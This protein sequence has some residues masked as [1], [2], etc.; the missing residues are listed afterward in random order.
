MA[1]KKRK[2]GRKKFKKVSFKVSSREQSL[3]EQC[4]QLEETTLNKFIKKAIREKVALYE[5]QLK[6]QNKSHVSENQLTLFSE[7]KAGDQISIFDKDLF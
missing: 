7:K 3:I 1:P 6:G 4:S 5:D 2:P